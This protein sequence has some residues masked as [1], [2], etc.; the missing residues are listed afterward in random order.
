MNQ[1]A[2]SAIRAQRLRRVRILN[3]L[4]K[5]SIEETRRQH[6]SGVEFFVKREECAN[7][8]ANYFLPEQPQESPH[9]DVE[10]FRTGLKAAMRDHPR[11]AT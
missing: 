1:G 11:R 8:R 9:D 6:F 2:V 3:G 10:S 5:I 7:Y 4:T